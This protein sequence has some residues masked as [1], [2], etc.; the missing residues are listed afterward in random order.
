[1]PEC[2]FRKASSR[3]PMP[4]KAKKELRVLEEFIQHPAPLQR[5]TASRKTASVDMAPTPSVS[6]FSSS[7][8]L[9]K[10]FN[11]LPRELRD[12]IYELVYDEDLYVVLGRRPL[13]AEP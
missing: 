13:R 10:T 11:G 2:R 1:V 8:S 3:H 12:Y 9:R 6:S 7:S 5:K 4:T